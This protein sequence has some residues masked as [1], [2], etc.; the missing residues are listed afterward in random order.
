MSYAMLYQNA[1]RV[2][3]NDE[4]LMRQAL[5]EHVSKVERSVLYQGKKAFVNK[6]RIDTVYRR[7]NETQY[8]YGLETDYYKVVVSFSR[9]ENN[10]EGYAVLVIKEESE[11]LTFKKAYEEG[12]KINLD[13]YEFDV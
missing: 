4:K 13:E 9:I 6:I 12:A 11:L 3:E 10:P 7:V 8:G 2:R 1:K 5:K